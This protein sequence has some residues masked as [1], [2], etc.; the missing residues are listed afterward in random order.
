MRKHNSHS[1]MGKTLSADDDKSQRKRNNRRQQ[2][3]FTLFRS[4]GR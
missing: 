3:N 2:V 1:E 4:S